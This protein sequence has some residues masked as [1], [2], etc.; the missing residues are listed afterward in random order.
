MKKQDLEKMLMDPEGLKRLS[1]RAAGIKQ[2]YG[3]PDSAA[4]FAS[5]IR[6]TQPLAS[7][8]RPT[9]EEVRLNDLDHFER[10]PV[11]ANIERFVPELAGKDPRE[12]L[13]ILVS[14]CKEKRSAGSEFLVE[15]AIN[16]LTS[17]GELDEY[18]EKLVA[19]AIKMLGSEPGKAEKDAGVEGDS[20]WSRVYQ[21]SDYRGRSYFINHGPGWVYRRIRIGSLN[22][23]NLNDAISSLYVDA[24]STEAGGNVFL[25]QHDRFTGRYANFPT[26]PGSPSTAR[27]TSYV[28]D[29]INDRTSSILVVRRYSNELVPIALG[30]LGLRDEIADYAGAVPRISLRGD[31]IIT[32]D[33]W[34]EGP[35]SGSDPHPNEPNRR[36]IYV[37]VPIEVDVPN[38]WDYDA[39]I[40][41]WIYPYVSAA[42]NLHA[43]V[44]YYGAWVEGGV[45]HDAILDRLMD[46]LPDTVGEVNARL[47][48]ALGIAALFAP[49]ARQ[50]FLP[51]TAGATGNTSDDVTLVLVRR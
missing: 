45:K 44:D 22:A 16:R 15:D 28:G 35:A 47:A 36:Y 13:S 27:L 42:G 1:E 12:A 6:P 5:R 19:D 50:Y 41:Y 51:G 18:G 40:R 30:S 21:H 11:L 20:I 7:E 48:D 26:T 32:W 49:Y 14:R 33:M 31:P 25:F 24:S 43:Y 29:F 46:A 17:Q 23:A 8:I 10:R 2:K 38:W 3:E 34:P 9:A 4:Q 37:R 39:D